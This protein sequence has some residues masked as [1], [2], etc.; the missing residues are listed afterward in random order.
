M[1]MHL[2]EKETFEHSFAL[3]ILLYYAAKSIGFGMILMQLAFSTYPHGKKKAHFPAL[4]QLTTGS[5]RPAGLGV[6]LVRPKA[7]GSGWQPFSLVKVGVIFIF[8]FDLI[9]YLCNHT[10]KV[11]L[12]ITNFSYHEQAKSYKKITLVDNNLI[13][14]NNSL[15]TKYFYITCVHVPLMIGLPYSWIFFSKHLYEIIMG[16]RSSSSQT[17]Y[18]K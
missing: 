14:N 3:K 15:Y 6:N 7:S 10:A 8:K 4:W 17:I 16:E 11:D 2:L 12:G 18:S 9:N 5:G 13:L 1:L